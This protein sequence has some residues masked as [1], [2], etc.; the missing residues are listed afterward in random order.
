MLRL[1]AAARC[2]QPARTHRFDGLWF[3]LQR[4]HDTSAGSTVAEVL[5][6][7]VE[8][9]PTAYG[10]KINCSGFGWRADGIT[11]ILPLKDGKTVLLFGVVHNGDLGMLTA[12]DRSFMYTYAKDE[13]QKPVPTVDLG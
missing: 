1:R 9:V 8:C 7:P 5:P 3:Q 4:I 6:P 12:N 11:S 10:P 13:N 2:E